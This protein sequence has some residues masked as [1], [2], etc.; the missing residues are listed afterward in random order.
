MDYSWSAVS[1]SI[2]TVNTTTSDLAYTTV[3]AFHE[4]D[5]KSIVGLMLKALI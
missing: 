3:H 1:G 2:D 5:K 4:K